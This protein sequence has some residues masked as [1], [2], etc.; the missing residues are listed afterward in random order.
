VGRSAAPV[1]TAEGLLL[2]AAMLAAAVFWSERSQD[3]PA[4]ERLAVAVLAVCTAQAL[5]GAAQSARGIGPI[6]GQ[7]A[8]FISSPF[9]SFVNHNHF[10]GL[11]E[12]GVLLSA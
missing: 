9:G 2:L 1:W 10:A 4:A 5:F 7:R 11:M 6:Y 12:M 3:R 8:Y